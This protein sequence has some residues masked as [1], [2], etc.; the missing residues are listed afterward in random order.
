[1]SPKTLCGCLWPLSKDCL[2]SEM[3]SSVRHL[4]GLIPKQLYNLKKSKKGCELVLIPATPMCARMLNLKLDAVNMLCA[5][6]YFL[7]PL[8]RTYIRF[9]KRNVMSGTK[10]D[11][12]LEITLLVTAPDTCSVAAVMLINIWWLGAKFCRPGWN[13]F[14]LIESDHRRIISNRP[15]HSRG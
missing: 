12:K 14:F 8:F 13:V 15:C 1:M 7:C 11:T 9:A 2:P 10:C 3:W 4:C 5:S 6:F